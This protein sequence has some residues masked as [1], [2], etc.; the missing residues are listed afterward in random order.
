MLTLSGQ[1]GLFG[2]IQ[3][4]LGYVDTFRAGWAMLTLS[5]QA[6]LFRHVQC[7]LGY[8]DTFHMDHGIFNMRT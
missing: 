1:A 2:H 4:R 7:R 6:G 8:V 5:V 3:C